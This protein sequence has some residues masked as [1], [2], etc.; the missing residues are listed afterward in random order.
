[1]LIITNNQKVMDEADPSFDRLFIDGTYEDVLLTVRD[2]IH[3]GHRLLTHPLSGSVKPGQTPYKSI[4]ISKE[5]AEL[6]LDSLKMIEDSIR[7]YST[8]TKNKAGYREEI[9][10][11]AAEDF[12]EV[13]ARLFAGALESAARAAKPMPENKEEEIL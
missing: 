4:L 2:R 12:R 3:K 7:T 9:Q 11:A 6:H 13:D 1:M 8:Q 10:K 5:A